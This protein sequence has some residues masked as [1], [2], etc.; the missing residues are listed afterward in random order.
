[1]E[2]FEDTPSQ[3]LGAN[4][5]GK[6]IDS[7]WDKINHREIDLK[8]SN[9][10]TKLFKGMATPAHGYTPLG[11]IRPPQ[12]EDVLAFLQNFLSEIMVIY[13]QYFDRLNIPLTSSTLED[14]WTYGIKPKWERMVIWLREFL[15]EEFKSKS[16]NIPNLNITDIYEEGHDQWLAKIEEAISNE[17]FGVAQ[18]AADQQNQPASGGGEETLSSAAPVGGS[19]SESQNAIGQATKENTTR[20][21]A[22]R[23]ASKSVEKRN[24]KIAV[25]KKQYEHLKGL[26]RYKIIA[27]KLD[28]Q[29][30]PRPEHWGVPTY[31]EALKVE[32]TRKAF[33]RM[34]S[35]AE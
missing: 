22:G 27:Q 10:V 11:Y 14:I 8:A 19:Q 30:E 29:N 24:T 15:A 34:V 5:S 31:K 33:Q 4:T 12:L 18:A 2:R 7:S 1:M 25:L 32:K 17:K 16:P 28:E 26:N 3:E 20:K 21:K 13:V 9:L 6:K 23:E 35:K